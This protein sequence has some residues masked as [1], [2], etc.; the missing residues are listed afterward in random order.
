MKGTLLSEI[1]EVFVLPDI[2]LFWCYLFIIVLWFQIRSIVS[3]GC[4]SSGF[5]NLW[6]S[7]AC[8]W[9]QKSE[10][11]SFHPEFANRWELWQ[12]SDNIFLIQMMRCQIQMRTQ[13][14]IWIYDNVCVNCVC[15]S[16]PKFR[17][18]VNL[19]SSSLVIYCLLFECT[20]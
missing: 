10:D 17:N 16:M 7:K 1:S 12:E 8:Q 13:M 3:F 19:H 2:C 20:F 11:T 15:G 9:E 14:M 6:W 5:W 18:L 4:F